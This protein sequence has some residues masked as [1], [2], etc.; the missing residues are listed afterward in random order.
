MTDEPG[1]AQA[2]SLTCNFVAFSSDVERGMRERKQ[3]SCDNLPTFLYVERK[4]GKQGMCSANI[5]TNIRTYT[6]T[7]TLNLKLDHVGTSCYA[8][9]S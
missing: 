6:Q 3:N 7:Q 5:Y 9:N 4:S 2:F 8:A 1:P